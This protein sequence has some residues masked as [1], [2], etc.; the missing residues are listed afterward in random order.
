MTTTTMKLTVPLE[1]VAL[2][3]VPVYLASGGRQV[4]VN[5]LL[6][7]GSSRSYLNSDVA[8]ELGLDGRPHELT[9]KV[10]NDNQ[11]KLNFSIVEF[12]INSL[13]GRVHKQASAYTTERVTGNMQVLNWNLYKS[14]WKH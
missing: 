11:E 12:M 6:D 1:F 2:R 9:V 14:K 8:A 3:T 7:E 10:L 4:K 13:D 5:A